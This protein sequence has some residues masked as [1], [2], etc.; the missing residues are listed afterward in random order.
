MALL[1][2]LQMQQA[3]YSK[4]LVA[5]PFLILTANNVLQDIKTFNRRP[6]KAHQFNLKIL[7]LL[8]FRCESRLSTIWKERIHIRVVLAYARG[9]KGGERTVH[10]LRWIPNQTSVLFSSIDTEP[11]TAAT[12]TDRGPLIA[13]SSSVYYR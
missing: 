4:P 5:F 10:L 9:W 6:R 2:K 1:C 12:S 8:P 11:L 13:K 3:I 7:Y